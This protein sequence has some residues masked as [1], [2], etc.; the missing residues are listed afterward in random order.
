MRKELQDL[1]LTL[2]H[3]EEKQLILILVKG[4]MEVSS[5]SGEIPQKSTAPKSKERDV[6]PFIGTSKNTSTK[7][8]VVNHSPFSRLVLQTHLNFSLRWILMT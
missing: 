7:K 6:N 1:R 3:S 5:E 8:E 2:S 4:K